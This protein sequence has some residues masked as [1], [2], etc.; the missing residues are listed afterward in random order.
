MTLETISGISVDKDST[1]VEVD[2]LLEPLTD[3]LHKNLGTLYS[4][5]PTNLSQEVI[6]KK[7]EDFL[8]IIETILVPNIYSMIEKE[9]RVM[10]KRQVSIL[11]YVIK[12]LLDFFHGDG[13]GLAIR[14]MQTKRYTD[15]M[16]L[17]SM[18]HQSITILKSE[19]ESSVRDGREKMLALRLVRLKYDK[20]DEL[21]PSEKEEG[22]RWIE[23]Q[24]SLLKDKRNNRS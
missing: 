19:F 9:R 12:V 6:R 11:K 15:I 8:L 13:N 7:W 24:L 18:H 20:L 5:L 2:I 14:T 23:S 22:K 1:E 17:L 16:G 3:F 21:D 4:N 10:N